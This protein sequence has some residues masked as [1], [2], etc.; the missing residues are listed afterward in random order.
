MS[1]PYLQQI[2]SIPSVKGE[3]PHTHKYASEEL[4]RLERIEALMKQSEWG[5]WDELGS[6]CWCCN[7][8]Q[9]SGH[10]SD[11]A[12]AAALEKP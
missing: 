3:H 9:S 2:L 5:A 4:A 10:E 1:A 11:C 12:L 7:R 6:F 8:S